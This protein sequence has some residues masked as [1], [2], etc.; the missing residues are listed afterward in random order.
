MRKCTNSLMVYYCFISDSFNFT[1]PPIKFVDTVTIE[2]ETTLNYSI[3]CRTDDPNATTSLWHASRKLKVQGRISLDRQ[4]YTIHGLK[5]SDG[6]AYQ[7]QATSSQDGAQIQQS[8]ILV[9]YQ[10]NTLKSW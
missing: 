9:I 4:V 7:C 5:T 8:F 2:I 10:G 6:G 3:N 1:D